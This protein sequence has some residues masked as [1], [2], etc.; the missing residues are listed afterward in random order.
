MGPN[1]N[2]VLRIGFYGFLSGRHTTDLAPVWSVWQAAVAVAT[3]REGSL[4]GKEGH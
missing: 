2:F 4:V 1:S 3:E